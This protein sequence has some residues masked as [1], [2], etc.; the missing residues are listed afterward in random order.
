M[1]RPEVGLL[2]FH[3]YGLLCG[4]VVKVL[5]LDLGELDSDPQYAVEPCWEILGLPFSLSLTILTG[6]L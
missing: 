3:P 1:K 5:N 4:V 6:L 2:E